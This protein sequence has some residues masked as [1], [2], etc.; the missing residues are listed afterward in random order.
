MFNGVL[1]MN[2][3]IHKTFSQLGHTHNAFGVCN[4]NCSNKAIKCIYKIL[5]VF[6]QLY[7]SVQFLCT[8]GII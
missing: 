7:K 1:F 3:E 2:Y 5:L 6:N 8:G 4:C